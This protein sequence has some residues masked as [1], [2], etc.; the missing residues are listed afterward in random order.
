MIVSLQIA[1]KTMESHPVTE[2]EGFEPSLLTNALLERA[3]SHSAA[4][5]PTEEPA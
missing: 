2:K 1:G 3:G 4:S 5:E